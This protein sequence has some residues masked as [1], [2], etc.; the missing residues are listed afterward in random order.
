MCIGGQFSSAV[1]VCRRD[2]RRRPPVNDAVIAAFSARME[3]VM[4]TYA[5]T[6]VFNKD[7]TSW[8]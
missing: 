3:D 1:S 6:C 7:E 4:A 2:L 8:H 5:A